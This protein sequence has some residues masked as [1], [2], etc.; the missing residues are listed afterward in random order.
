[1]HLRLRIV[2]PVVAV[3]MPLVFISHIACA[4]VRTGSDGYGGVRTGTEPMNDSGD[5]SIGGV[6]TDSGTAATDSDSIGGY[7]P[8]G[9]DSAA[10]GGVR[11]APPP[12]AAPARQYHP[13][14]GSAADMMRAANGL[15]GSVREARGVEQKRPPLGF[16][17]AFI[18]MD[19][20]YNG[21]V[22]NGIKQLAAVKGL[23]FR[24]Y[25]STSDLNNLEKLK[26]MAKNPPAWM[27]LSGGGQNHQAEQ[28]NPDDATP[29]IFSD[30][31][32]RMAS[33]LGVTKRP[34]VVYEMPDGTT[35]KIS[36]A[37]SVD[38]VMRLIQKAQRGE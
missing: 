3:V 18:D 20:F 22:M 35:H 8:P 7:A 38:G 28:D 13:S 27:N 34:T 5:I 11:Q 19:N 17:V 14:G 25:Q 24:V 33:G 36:I 9:T 23:D 15:R 31:G 37:H 6:N 16:A 4:Q 10:A 32:D 2:W 1:M 29:E 12:P 26:K 30:T 21:D